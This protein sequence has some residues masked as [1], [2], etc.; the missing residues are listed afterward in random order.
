MVK[1]S[2]WKIV[3]LNKIVGLKNGRSYTGV[4]YRGYPM[5]QTEF[6]NAQMPHAAYKILLM[7][8]AAYKKA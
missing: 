3:G 1:K 4:G 5:P 6:K 7:P 2:T 8:H